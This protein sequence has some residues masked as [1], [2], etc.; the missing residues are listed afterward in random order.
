MPAFGS[1]LFAIA[2]K[3]VAGSVEG[4]AGVALSNAV[5]IKASTLNVR[6]G[7]S[8]GYGR[9]GTTTTGQLFIRQAQQSGWNKI[10][11]NGREGWLSGRSSYSEPVSF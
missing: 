5:K 11:W 3:S 8:T 7:P 6:S 2:T 9:L 4:A 1:A 10:Y